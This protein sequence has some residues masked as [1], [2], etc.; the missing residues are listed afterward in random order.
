MKWK[1]YQSDGRYNYDGHDENGQQIV[2][3]MTAADGSFRGTD[4]RYA[5][6]ADPE[7]PYRFRFPS[8]KVAKDA[9]SMSEHHDFDMLDCYVD[10]ELE[11]LGKRTVEVLRKASAAIESARHRKT[12][13]EQ[14]SQKVVEISQTSPTGEEFFDAMDKYITENA[15]S[16]M[17]KS[18]LGMVPEGYPII[19]SG[20]FGKSMVRRM[21]EGSI[22]PMPYR[23]YGGGIR[24]GGEVK[25][26]EST[27]D[28]MKGVML[29]DSIYGGKTFYSLRDHL[30]KEGFSLVRCLVVYDGNPAER[31]EVAAV[32]R[33]YDEHPEARPNFK[34]DEKGNPVV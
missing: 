31:A 7:R 19:L 20:G 4:L 15:T 29:D 11:N 16:E 22:D 33:Y 26:L 1:R 18:L 30:A 9:F 17:L 14:I 25:L 8:L 34:F 2:H 13:R 32:Y 27:T 28:E 10:R 5:G 12:A 21:K 6:K 3:L 24:K 23:L